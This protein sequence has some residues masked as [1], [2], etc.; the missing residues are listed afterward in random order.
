METEGKRLAERAK[1]QNQLRKRN[2][3]RNGA[4]FMYQVQERV[5]YKALFALVW[6][7]Q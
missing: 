5:P 1:P 2:S 4:Y 7:T 6:T 3:H